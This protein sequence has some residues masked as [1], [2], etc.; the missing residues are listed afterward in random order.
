MPL[1]DINS[2][3]IAIKVHVPEQF[4][5]VH[6]YINIYLFCIKSLY[7]RFYTMLKSLYNIDSEAFTMIVGQEIN[8]K[9]WGVRW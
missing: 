9:G 2:N 4:I 3:T 6:R 7:H 5:T 1:K 8:E